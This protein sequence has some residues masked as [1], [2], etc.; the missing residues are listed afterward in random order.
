[1]PE[2]ANFIARVVCTAIASE[3]GLRSYCGEEYE[4]V[5]TQI[6]ENKGT[7]YSWENA[8]IAE[9]DGKPAGGVVAYDWAC[10]HPLRSKTWDIW[11]RREYA[12][13]PPQCL[14]PKRVS[15]DNR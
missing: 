2:D 8:L 9:V 3:E 10:L 12:S 7:Q 13:E 4:K 14:V 5:I 1:M 6:A 11:R 15:V